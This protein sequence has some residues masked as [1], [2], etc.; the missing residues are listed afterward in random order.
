MF[1]PRSIIPQKVQFLL[2]FWKSRSRVEFGILNFN[3]QNIHTDTLRQ[4]ATRK[5]ME[6][7]GA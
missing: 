2:D 7:H 6:G 4:T 3:L 5:K 1:N